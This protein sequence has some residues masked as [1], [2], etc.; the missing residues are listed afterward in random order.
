MMLSCSISANMWISFSISLIA[1]PRRELSTL[2][3][4]IYLAA[5]SVLKHSCTQPW[6]IRYHYTLLTFLWLGEPQQTPHWN[7]Q[8]SLQFRWYDDGYAWCIWM[9]NQREYII[10]YW[11]IIFHTVSLGAYHQYAIYFSKNCPTLFGKWYLPTFKIT[12]LWYAKHTNILIFHNRSNILIL[13][14]RNN[15]LK[16][17]NRS[18]ANLSIVQTFIRQLVYYHTN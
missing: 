13:R 9:I 1:T 15:I 18:E 3:F 4:F 2:F 16:F 8:I 10:Q 17:P 14:N 12:K 5:Y 7:K 11:I 6:H